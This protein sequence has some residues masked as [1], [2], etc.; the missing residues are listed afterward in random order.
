MSG[1]GP[2]GFVAMDPKALTVPAEKMKKRSRCGGFFYN[3]CR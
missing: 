3:S 2:E 1:I